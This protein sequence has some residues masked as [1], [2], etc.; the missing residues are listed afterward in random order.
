M[1]T[2]LFLSFLTLSSISNGQTQEAKNTPINNTPAPVNVEQTS[3]VNKINKR[4]IS[5]PIKIVAPAKIEVNK[6]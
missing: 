6:N 2:L 3:K 1:K 4:V 5:R